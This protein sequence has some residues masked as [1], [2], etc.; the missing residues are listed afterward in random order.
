MLC[1]LC[2]R[3][4]NA[5]REAT[6]GN[7]FCGAGTLALVSR[8]APHYWEEPCISGTRGSGTVFFSGCSLGCVFC[9]NDRISRGP[10]PGKALDAAALSRLFRRVEELGVHNINLVTPTHFTPVIAE[11]LQLYKPA[12]PVVWN[13]GGYEKPETLQALK[14]LVDIFLPDFKYA[15]SETARE[16]AQAPDYF[17]KA[18]PAIQ[19][20]CELSG[21]PVYDENGLMQSGT[22]VRHLVL[23]LRVQETIRLLDVIA[24]QLPKGTPVSL[25]RQYTPLGHTTAKGLDRPLT[26]REYDR[27]VQH[28]LQLGLTGYTQGAKAVKESFIPD[29]L[30]EESLRLMS[31]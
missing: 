4:C 3:N 14:G 15:T 26:A 12:I 2:P 17:E 7:G 29:F 31:D 11:A 23:P 30:D 25:M 21:P 10:L 6:H 28:M 1:H 19:T 22:I 9:Q 8:A 5:L 16:L 18:L 27:A 24:E 13:S 20:M